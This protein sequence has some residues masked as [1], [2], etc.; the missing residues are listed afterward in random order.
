MT[1]R[2]YLLTTVSHPAM[3]TVMTPGTAR[4]YANALALSYG[5]LH[6]QHLNLAPVG[7]P[8]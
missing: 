7:R 1:L 5:G 4:G 2:V 3:R 8:H 6:L